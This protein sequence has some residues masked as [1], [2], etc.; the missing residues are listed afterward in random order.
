MILQQG[1][2]LTL[3]GVGLGLALAYVLVR[4]LESLTSLL[5]GVRPTDDGG[6]EI[7]VKRLAFSC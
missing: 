4:Y 1:M 5:Y 7:R 3:L 6:A 2:T